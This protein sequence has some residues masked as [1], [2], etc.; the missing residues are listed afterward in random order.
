MASFLKR[1]DDF[2]GMS[3]LIN[4]GAY[5][6]IIVPE[7]QKLVAFFRRTDAEKAKEKYGE[8]VKELK[9][10]IALVYFDLDL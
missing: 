6:L 4:E 9:N 5:M 10:G 1:L 7:K 8:R 2:K 3:D